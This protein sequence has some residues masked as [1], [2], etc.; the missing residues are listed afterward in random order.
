[1]GERVRAAEAQAAEAQRRVS[2][3]QE[4]VR[5]AKEEAAREA[6]RAASAQKSADSTGKTAAIAA[7]REQLEALETLRLTRE[8]LQNAK[9]RNQE[10]ARAIEGIRE[11]AKRTGSAPTPESLA[12]LE[13]TQAVQEARDQVAVL[14]ARVK[15]VE[16]QLAAQQAEW[17][18]ERT[19]LQQ[20]LDDAAA[21]LARERIRFA[22]AEA[23]MSSATSTSATADAVNSLKW[24]LS[25][26]REAT[27]EAARLA[28]A[29]LAR[30]REAADE[31]ARLAAAELS[32]AQRALQYTRAELQQS[33]RLLQAAMDEVQRE[34]AAKEAA[35]E[36]SMHQIEGVIQ[37]ADG[38]QEAMRKAEWDL[39]RARERTDDLER[40]AAEA[41]ALKADAEARAAMAEAQYDELRAQAEAALREAKEAKEAQQ[42]ATAAKF[43][44]EA[45]AQSMKEQMDA[46]TADA[47]SQRIQIT[48]MLR[49]AAESASAEH[50]VALALAQDALAAARA[51]LAQER[52]FAAERMGAFQAAHGEMQAATQELLR[53][54]V[55]DQEQIRKLT[56]EVEHYSAEAEAA[57][58]GLRAAKAE[59]EVAVAK[60]KDQLAAAGAVARCLREAAAFW[61]RAVDAPKGTPGWEAAE[62]LVRAAPSAVAFSREAE[63]LLTAAQTD[64]EGVRA[65]LRAGGASVLACCMALHSA[66]ADVQLWSADLLGRVAPSVSDAADDHLRMMQPL[67]VEVLVLALKQHTLSAAVAEAS[68]SALA[69]FLKRSGTFVQQAVDCG[70]VQAARA[71]LNVH[72]ESKGVQEAGQALMALF[73]QSAL[74]AAAALAEA[75][76]VAA[77]AAAEE[78]Q[79]PAQP[80]RAPAPAP[81][82]PLPELQ[83]ALAPLPA[84]SSYAAP[85]SPVPASPAAA[86]GG[87][88]DIDAIFA[89]AM[90]SIESIA[91][92]GAGGDPL[93]SAPLQQR[94][95]SRSRPE[96]GEARPGSTTPSQPYESVFAH[97]R[98]LSAEPPPARSSPS[99]QPGTPTR[100]GAVGHFGGAASPAPQLQ[101]HDNTAAAEAEAAAREAE[102]A[103][104]MAEEAAAA[105][106]L[107]AEEAAMQEEEDKQRCVC[108]VLHQGHHEHESA[109]PLIGLVANS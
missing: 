9:L 36:A 37:E 10:L 30:Q 46:V 56:A 68:M 73:P 67:A 65:A 66:S 19:A 18:R 11:E 59:R 29:E 96:A 60:A 72:G 89:A 63:A 71:A 53:D 47:E 74:Q 92:D 5:A 105:A 83:A 24:E 42:A 86:A 40:I 44:A 88:S 98:P 17:G 106:A 57:T 103:L 100:G 108:V 78:Q 99:P 82:A 94:G 16:A 28:A 79:R 97:F 52:E 20:T 64:P 87:A 26:Q 38:A 35:V 69:R 6:A 61:A 109:Y 51:E 90:Q 23:A 77:A 95:S 32:E 4:E 25:R 39:N 22:E 33:S 8:E 13:R 54:K 41:K 50:S 102:A 58:A 21:N 84:A 15:E 3:L 91:V 80:R 1:M 14:T 27:N 12:A 45:Q 70:A 31:A 43:R 107:A 62:R 75:E 93:F 48:T 55:E 104:A 85:A 7:T 76:T 2:A 81:A 34:R 101:Q 49:Q